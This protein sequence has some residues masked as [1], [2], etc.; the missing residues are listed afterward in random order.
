ML[1]RFRRLRKVRRALRALR[2]HWNNNDCNSLCG[3]SCRNQNIVGS[4]PLP[5]VALSGQLRTRAIQNGGNFF[6]SLSS[7]LPAAA[8]AEFWLPLVVWFAGWPLASGALAAAGV[9]DESAGGAPAPDT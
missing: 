1:A 5:L 8:P 2:A 4:E 9:E 3:A 6:L 7:A